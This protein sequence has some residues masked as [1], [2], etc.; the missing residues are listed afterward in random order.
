MDTGILYLRTGKSVATLQLETAAR[1]AASTY[2]R[3]AADNT[4]YR[5][6]LK[7]DVYD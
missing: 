6:D 2:L 4:A 7:V 5:R 1:L 3:K